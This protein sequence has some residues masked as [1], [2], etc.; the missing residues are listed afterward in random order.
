[1][2]PSRR[3]RMSIFGT[4]P[5]VFNCK[6]AWR[7][8]F[9]SFCIGV[10]RGARGKSVKTSLFATSELR[11]LDFLMQYSLLRPGDLRRSREICKARLIRGHNIA[12]EYAKV[13]SLFAEPH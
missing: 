9:F 3:D 7:L 12:Y 6:N 5:H 8:V 1:M 10:F 4:Q 11:A 13:V 2:I